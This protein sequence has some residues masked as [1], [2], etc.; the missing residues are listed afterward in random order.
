MT[1][2]RT[3]SAIN[4]SGYIKDRRVKA[5]TPINLVVLNVRHSR[6]MAKTVETIIKIPFAWV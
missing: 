1:P 2:P 4:N 5:M 6:L 3:R